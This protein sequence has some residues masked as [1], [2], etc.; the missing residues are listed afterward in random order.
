M[1]PSPQP[2]VD[3]N[4]TRHCNA[5]AK[6]WQH[7][8][9]LTTAL[10]KSYPVSCRRQGR[11]MHH[12]SSLL[13]GQHKHTSPLHG[14]TGVQCITRCPVNP[15]VVMAALNNVVCN[16]QGAKQAPGASRQSINSNMQLHPH[17]VNSWSHTCVLPNQVAAGVGALRT[18]QLYMGQKA[19]RLIRRLLHLQSGPTKSM[20]LPAHTPCMQHTAAS[21]VQRTMST[22]HA[23]DETKV[24]GWRAM[25]VHDDSS[26]TLGVPETTQPGHGLVT[27]AEQHGAASKPRNSQYT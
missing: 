11:L 2:A 14:Q 16:M 12:L 26:S 5:H 4:P 25:P 1:A 19:G 17:P 8:R 27:F 13:R 7:T 20:T 23:T 15:A 21:A 24:S 9:P 3:H 10:L 6:C 22:M 18:R